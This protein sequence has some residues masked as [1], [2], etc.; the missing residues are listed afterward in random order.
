MALPS[1]EKPPIK[2]DFLLC[3]KFC[4]T[5]YVEQ[6]GTFMNV[7]KEGPFFTISPLQNEVAESGLFVHSTIYRNF[8]FKISVF[9]Y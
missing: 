5:W 6:K 8:S 3:G 9:C 7:H 2:M 4:V 1:V